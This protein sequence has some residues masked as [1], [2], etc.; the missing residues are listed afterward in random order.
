LAYP[1]FQ[2]IGTLRN[3]SYEMPDPENF[4][5]KSVEWVAI[6]SI[7]IGLSLMLIARRVTGLDSDNP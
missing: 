6:V 4:T 1:T 2:R 7:L 5:L 3:H